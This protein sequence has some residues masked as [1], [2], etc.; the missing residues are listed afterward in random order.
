MNKCIESAINQSY[1]NIEIILVDDGST[2]ESGN[3]C[4]KWQK[5]DSRIRVFHKIN[6]GVSDARNTGIAT[7]SGD[8]VCFI[9]GDD[10]VLPEYVAY[11]YTLIQSGPYDISLTTRMFGN[12]DEHQIEEHMVSEWTAED[13]VESILCY[14]VP[15]GCY[16]KLF[17][18]KI[19]N[20]IR[21]IKDVYIGEGF[22]FNVD[23]FQHADNVIAGNCKVYYYRRDNTA[24]AMS[25]FSIKKTECGLKAL[26]IIKENLIF[27]SPRIE[28]A[29]EF[30][31]WRTHSDFYDMIVLAGAQ[32][33]YPEMY[34]K[35]K[36]VVRRDAMIALYV[37]I[38]R[39]NKI[40]A[41]L[42]WIWPDSIPIAMRM[43]AKRYRTPVIS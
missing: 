39:Q 9:D 37:P 1:S 3:I 33:Q 22:N 29:W 41:I 36:T 21:F 14:H 10:Y 28:K 32:K 25:K 35:L 43:R 13:A 38:S 16:C 30:A 15:I 6:A 11:L 34:K 23:A 17:T 31:N 40:R 42:M 20:D 12:F 2:D 7:S 24:S 19:I 27:H 4:D 5:K 8:Y 26:E 18:K